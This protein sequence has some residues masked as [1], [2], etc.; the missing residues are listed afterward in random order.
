MIATLTALLILLFSFSA[1]ADEV[2]T[3]YEYKILHRQS[4]RGTVWIDRLNAAG[5]EGW[6]LVLLKPQFYSSPMQVYL[7]RVKK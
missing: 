2:E 4:Y 7:M 3:K 5:D 1:H 6:K